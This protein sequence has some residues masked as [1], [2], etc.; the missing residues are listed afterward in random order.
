MCWLKQFAVGLL[1]P[2]CSDRLGIA[3]SNAELPK[4]LACSI[5]RN[6]DLS[7]DPDDDADEEA[8]PDLDFVFIACSHAFHEHCLAGHERGD[9]DQRWDADFKCPNCRVTNREAKEIEARRAAE[10]R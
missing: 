7:E 3:A 10:G 6:V 8:E 1:T 4:E 2:E 5:C 9:K